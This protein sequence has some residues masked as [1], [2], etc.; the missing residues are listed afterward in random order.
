MKVD[1]YTVPDP[2]TQGRQAVPEAET[3]FRMLIAE[4]KD[5]AKRQ[6]LMNAASL[7]GRLSDEVQAYRDAAELDPAR[8]PSMRFRGWNMGRLARARRLTEAALGP[9]DRPSRP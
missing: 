1:S 2:A 5:S 3:W 4:E 7:L 6:M 8:P 9:G